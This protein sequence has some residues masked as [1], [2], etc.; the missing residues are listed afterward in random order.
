M[1]ISERRPIIDLGLGDIDSGLQLSGEAGWNQTADDWHHFIENGHGIGVRDD[2]GQLVAS[3]ATLPFDGEFGFISMV[4][5]TRN[6]RRRGLATRLVE[7]C[8]DHLAA[9]ALIP[10]LDAT[11]DGE[12]VYRKQGF[13][14][15]FR[16]DRWQN[17]LAG[18]ARSADGPEQPPHIHEIAMQ[19]ARA[20]GAKRQNLIRDF[21]SRDGAIFIRPPDGGGFA[22]M[23]RGR[24]ALQIGPVV[25]RSQEDAVGMLR[26]L[27]GLAVGPVFVDAPAVWQEVGALLRRNGFSVQRQFSRMALR[28]A[29]PFG[30]PSHL[31][32]VAGPEFG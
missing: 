32:A 16:F 28:R 6:W 19:D 4:L 13:V 29:E 5:V 10:V 8:I 2:D 11:E 30:D 23:R 7:Q 12:K 14:R 31:F 21:L 20:F 15:Q 27:F 17:I 22:I 9:D 24:R 26:R 3:A 25:A 18:T 1:A